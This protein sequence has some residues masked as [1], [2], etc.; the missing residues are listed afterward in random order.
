MGVQAQGLGSLVCCVPSLSLPYS[1]SLNFP[2]GAGVFRGD[3]KEWGVSVGGE[4]DEKTVLQILQIFP[5]IPLKS[6]I[7][8]GIVVVVVY[9]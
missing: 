9:R 2:Q 5:L 4:C 7:R 8:V 6:C 1:C 3:L